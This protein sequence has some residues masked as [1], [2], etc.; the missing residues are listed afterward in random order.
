MPRFRSPRPR[1]I[2][3]ASLVF[4]PLIAGGFAM[5]TRVSTDGARVFDQVLTLVSDRFVD[6]LDAAALY[7][8]AAQGL[9]HELNDPYSELLPPKRLTEF[10]RRTGGRYGGVGM[11]IEDIGGSIVVS[12]VFPHT[13]AEE[14]GVAEGDHITQVETATTQGWTLANVSDSLI[15]TVGTKVSVHFARPGVAEPIVLRFT[16]ALIHV[17]AVPYAIMLEG[18]IAY[19]PLQQF[20]EDA[21]E[22]LDAALKRLVTA[23]GAKGVVLD[24]RDDPG[25]ILDQSLE[26][27]N[28]FLSEGQ[29]LVSVR[30]R[31]ASTQIY[32]AKEKPL[33]PT[34]PLIVLVDG[35]TASA[36]EIVAGA[37]QDHDRGLIMG[38][39]SFGKGLVQT[40]FPLDAGYALKMTTAKWYTPSGRSIQKERKLLPD[41][42][43]IEVHPDSLET[44]SSRKARPAFKSDAGR[45]VYGGGAITPDV[46]IKPDTL[47]TQQQAFNKLIAP[48]IQPVLQALASLALDVKSTVKSPSFTVPPAWR[49]D[50]Y[51]RLQKAG[52]AIN[53]AQYDSMSSYVDRVIGGRVTL[54]AFGDSA[55]KRRDL[56]V[57][58]QLKKAVELLQRSQTQ[59]DLF[60]EAQQLAAVP[61][62]K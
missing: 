53:R 21:S 56:D 61:P 26:V 3:L 23:E 48:K 38:T 30:G 8:K 14:A 15:G 51:G 10:S 33:F 7:E 13:P 40:V 1:T 11:A 54:A 39:T 41:G 34:V 50:F 37:L 25:G 43:F 18:K 2:A 35:G 57:D 4:V 31:N 42:E 52:V 58:V 44:D 27:S 62:K 6:T 29:Q 47:T 16:R 22:D 9:V 17:P 12:K 46:V 49:D 45:T 59:K 36:S 60:D 24:L 55:Q 19:V 28:A 32:T 5:Q 20:N